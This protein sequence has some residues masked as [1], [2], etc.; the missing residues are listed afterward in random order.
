MFPG[1]L[2]TEVVNG[3]DADACSPVTNVY[4]KC[5][6]VTESQP[7]FVARPIT[8]HQHATDIMSTIFSK[9]FSYCMLFTKGSEKIGI[10]NNGVIEM[11]KIFSFCPDKNQV[12]R[13]IPK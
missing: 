1:A 8:H 4:I 3:Q 9:T 11:L 7:P 12:L 6:T 2:S 10:I 5:N 13:E